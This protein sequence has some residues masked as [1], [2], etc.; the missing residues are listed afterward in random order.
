MTAAEGMDTGAGTESL[1][2]DENG[3]SS[4]GFALESL[5]FQESSVF[6]FHSQ[7]APRFDHLQQN[8]VDNPNRA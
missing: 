7:N 8:E 3:F 4:R 6:D 1:S 5:P 2:F